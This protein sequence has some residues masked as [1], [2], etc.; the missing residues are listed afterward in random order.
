[1]QEKAIYPYSEW[2]LIEEQFTEEHNFRNET[3]FMTG[4]GYIGFRGTLEEGYS[5]AKGTGE[6]G[7]YINGFYES[8][9]I[10]YPERLYGYADN[11]DFMLNVTNSKIIKLFIDGEPFDMLQGQ[12]SGYSRVLSLKNGTLTRKLTWTSPHGKTVSIRIERLA[13]FTDRHIAA[14]RYEVTPVNFD[15]EI[16]LISALDGN[17][18]N[19][20]GFVSFLVGSEPKRERYLTTERIQ[21]ADGAGAIL[22]KTKRSGLALSCAMKNTLETSCPASCQSSAE[23]SFLSAAYTVRAARGQSIVLCKYIAYATSRDFAEEQLFDAAKD[24]AAKAA[25]AGFAR[26]RNDQIAYLKRFWDHAD[27]II[28]GDPALQQGIRVNMFHVLQSSGRDG[29]SAIGAKGLT[30][31]GFCGHYFWDTEM[32]IVPFFLYNDPSISRKLLEYRYYTLDKAREGARKLA[33]P[34]G[35]LYPWRTLSGEECSSY[36][37]A[38]TAQYHVNADIA[39]AIKQYMDATDDKDFL[40]H[41]GA[42][43][44]FET[45]RV[46]A[47]VG[48]YIPSKGNKFCINCVTGPDEYAVLVNNNCYTNF[49][50]RENLRFAFRTAE[51]MKAERPEAYAAL[52]EKIGLEAEELTA[53][54]SAADNM[55][56]PYDAERK[57]YWQDDNFMDRAPWDLAHTPAEEHPLVLHYHPLV[58]YRKQVC[59]QADVVHLQLL[60][61]DQFTKEEKKNCYDFYEK[62]T[63]HDAS[64]SACIFGIMASEV[65]YR[66]KAYEDFMLSARADIDNT[67]HLTHDGIGA[68]NMA[69]AWMGI[70]NGFAGMRVYDRTLHFDPYLPANWEEY[71]FKVTFRGRL[72]QITVTKHGARFALL[73]G[74]SI[75]LFCAGKEVVLA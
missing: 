74:E 45:A 65:G 73:E 33:H 31:E 49:M 47:D 52:A 39:L 6:E 46:W 71:S 40:E 5:G 67:H 72:I 70:V 43:I 23:D 18:T 11:N 28:K 57:L 42:E 64:M 60:L 37:P 19:Q 55:Y 66:E 44:L 7:T 16:K 32:F 24:L 13:S 61:G 14:I 75:H 34:K 20:A 56:I 36:F 63:A 8:G 3:M 41:Y 2:E 50:A 4:N 17:V 12:C 51:W 59:K 69:G 1:M 62:V 27:V 58:V 22:Q 29:K 26:L 9:A 15:G 54:K 53:W 30:A 35:A 48:A 38:S 10:E 68:A 25:Q 21:A